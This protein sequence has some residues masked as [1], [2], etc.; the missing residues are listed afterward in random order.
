MFKL[1]GLL[2]L[3]GLSYE[4]EF[5][6]VQTIKAKTI[7]SF[8]FTKTDAGVDK[9]KFCVF[10]FLLIALLRFLCFVFSSFKGHD[11]PRASECGGTGAAH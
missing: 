10:L 3:E 2:T 1:K 9:R 5:I 4:A 11:N 7:N 8:C 6:Q